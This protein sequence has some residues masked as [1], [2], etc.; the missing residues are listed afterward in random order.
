MLFAACSAIVYSNVYKYIKNA[1]LLILP[2]K[3]KNK[4]LTYVICTQCS[5]LFMCYNLH[6]NLHL[7]DCVVVMCRILWDKSNDVLLFVCELQCIG[8]SMP[9]FKKITRVLFSLYL[10][11][12]IFFL[13]ISD[14]YECP[15]VHRCI[16]AA[17]GAHVH[18]SR[19][20]ALPSNFVFLFFSF[21]LRR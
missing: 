10:F 15:V 3:Y 21:I 19:V 18:A 2:E 1:M 14:V 11:R 20:T 4:C 17:D 6:C 12:L 16:A 13:H 9:F 7:N 5:I 8:A